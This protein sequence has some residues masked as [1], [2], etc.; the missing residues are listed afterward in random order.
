[1]PGASI[2]LPP[3]TL[4]I[5][6]AESTVVISIHRGGNQATERLSILP[7]V[8]QLGDSRAGILIS[9]SLS[10]LP[11]LAERRDERDTH[12]MRNEPTCP[13]GRIVVSSA[14]VAHEGDPRRTLQP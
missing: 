13:V 9:S 4:V 10:F 7:K 1:M 11:G 3:L 8:A 12:R 5:S 14:S 6:S 2:S